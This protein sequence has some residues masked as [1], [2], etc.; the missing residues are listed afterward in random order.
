MVRAGAGHPVPV[1]PLVFEVGHVVV[2]AAGVACAVVVPEVAVVVVR[3][4]VV[5]VAG[6]VVV[7][8]TVK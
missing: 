7:V 1:A 3:T 8:R 4:V 6:M 2:P 5:P